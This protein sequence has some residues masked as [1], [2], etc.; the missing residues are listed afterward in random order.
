MSRR[1]TAEELLQIFQTLDRDGNGIVSRTELERGLQQA[2]VNPKSIERVMNDLDLNCDGKIALGEYKLALGLTDEP[3]AEWKQLF[4]SMDKDGSG[5]VTKQ[6]LKA[7]FDEM[8]MPISYSV[9]E[10][11]IADHDVNGDGNLNF[12]EFLGFIS[13][14]VE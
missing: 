13:E 3:L 1:V 6:E 2:G 14:Q 10:A 12:E 5:T 4:F 8:S 11:W 9:I 7:M